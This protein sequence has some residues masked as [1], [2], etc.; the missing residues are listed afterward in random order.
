MF[1]CPLGECFLSRN[2][3][4]IRQI[5]YWKIYRIW[6]I[7]FFGK[8]N[9]WSLSLAYFPINRDIGWNEAIFH[10][11]VYSFTG[12]FRPRNRKFVFFNRTPNAFRWKRTSKRLRTISFF[13]SPFWTRIWRPSPFNKGQ[14]F[15]A[16]Y[17]ASPRA[18]ATR[19]TSSR[20]FFGVQCIESR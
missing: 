19:E 6:F 1:G 13:W 7:Y 8:R 10:G 12:V 16:I 17:R 4:R 9:H 20:C 18:I 2:S 5:E 14:Q 11:Q 3:Y 15:W